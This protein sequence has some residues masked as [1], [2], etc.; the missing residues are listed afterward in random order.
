MTLLDIT[1]IFY[2][3]FCTK[4]GKEVNIIISFE[5]CI[6]LLC[7]VLYTPTL[8]T[9]LGVHTISNTRKRTSLIE[10]KATNEMWES[11][12]IVYLIILRSKGRIQNLHTKYIQAIP[13]LTC[14]S[15][16]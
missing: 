14:G 1:T 4:Q 11:V 10:K 8:Y 12:P 3:N 13:R 5:E 7:L 16:P 6:L 15:R 2:F 9:H